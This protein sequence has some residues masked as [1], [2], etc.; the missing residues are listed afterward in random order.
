MTQA[1]LPTRYPPKTVLHPPHERLCDTLVTEG[2]VTDDDQPN[3]SANPVSHVA[4][5]G[6]T[7]RSAQPLVPGSVKHLKISSG[8]PRLSSRIRVISC[9]PRS[10]GSFV[11]RA[12]FY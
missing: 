11:V 2:V 7:F 12:E 10:D 5:Q 1:T 4:L 8:Q 9:L 6:V 3:D